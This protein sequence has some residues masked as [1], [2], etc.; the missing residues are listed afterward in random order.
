M[1]RVSIKDVSGG[2]SSA[3][4]EKLQ[5]DGGYE[6]V[7]LSVRGGEVCAVVPTGT[8]DERVEQVVALLRGALR[9]ENERVLTFEVQPG[10]A[11]FEDLST[12]LHPHRAEAV[13]AAPTPARTEA[14]LTAADIMARNVVTIG[15]DMLVEDAAKLLAFHNISGMPVEDWDGKVVGII[16]EADVIG[17][18]GETV[19][20]V[21]STEVISMPE[22]TSIE[23]IAA[24]MSER[25][26][27]RVPVMSGESLLGM[28]SR[29][30]IV[31]ALAA[32]A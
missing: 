18:I 12:R 24:L 28:V 17:K 30:D 25:R 13:A 23:R 19:A 5:A 32:R 27:K 3:R 2:Q 11:S 26:I 20:D 7:V 15:A 21:M 9:L 22:D 14:S 8:P 31:R 1:K 4:L 10:A 29:A 6:A 16:S